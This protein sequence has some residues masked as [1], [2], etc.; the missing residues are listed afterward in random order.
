MRHASKIS[1]DSILDLDWRHFSFNGD[2]GSLTHI[3]R[4]IDRWLNVVIG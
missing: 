2:V 1:G 3:N 4:T